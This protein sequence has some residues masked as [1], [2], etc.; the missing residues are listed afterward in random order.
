M[1]KKHPKLDPHFVSNESYELQYIAA[2]FAITTERVRFAKKS[3]KTTSRRR[4][5]DFIRRNILK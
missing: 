2:K 5:Y 3:A 4:I 1:K